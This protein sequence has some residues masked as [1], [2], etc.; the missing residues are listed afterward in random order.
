VPTR[1]TEQPGVGKGLGGVVGGATGIFPAMLAVVA[2][3]MAI[4]GIGPLTA[5]GA[6]VMA[7]LGIGVR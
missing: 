1:E 5:I 2:A 3:S 6:T 7:L 4:H